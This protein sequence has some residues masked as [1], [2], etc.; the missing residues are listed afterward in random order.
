LIPGRGTLVKCAR[1]RDP[2]QEREYKKQDKQ[3][4]A[5]DGSALAPGPPCGSFE[6]DHGA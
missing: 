4:H 6:Q 3:H 5:A 1:K 2:D